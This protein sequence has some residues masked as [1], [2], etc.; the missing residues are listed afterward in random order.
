MDFLDALSIPFAVEADT[1]LRDGALY[2]I[3]TGLKVVITDGEAD[4]KSN[5]G[6]LT[7]HVWADKIIIR[8]SH[9][10]AYGSRCYGILS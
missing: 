9:E 10:V 4:C 7:P 5:K 6:S 3:T 2:L 8:G 1:R